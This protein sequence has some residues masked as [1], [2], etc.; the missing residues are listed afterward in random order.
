MTNPGPS[1]TSDFRAGAKVAALVLGVI[2]ALLALDRAVASILDAG[3]ARSGASPLAQVR[4]A[5]ADAV[6]VGTSTAKAA[7][8]PS[9]WPGKLVNLAQ[10]GQTVL[11][12]IAAARAML[13]APT[14][15]RIIIGIDPFDLASG[16]SNPAAQRIWRIA[17]LVA[18]LPE[19][20]PMLRQTRSV[21]EAPV[22]LESWRY[23]GE[24]GKIVNGLGKTD[25]PAYRPL[26]PGELREPQLNR[27]SPVRAHRMHASLEPYVT[28]LREMA[29]RPGR[30][31]VLVVTPAYR[32][33]RYDLPEQAQLLAELRQRLTG[34]PVCDLMSLDTPTLAQIRGQPANFFDNIH[35]SGQGA[36]AYTKELAA[37]VAAR[38]KS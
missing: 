37:L 23:R 22:A 36:A 24:V 14:V 27:S 25:P 35:L 4:H 6:V 2:A 17:P 9:I 8:V 38:C 30:Q 19:V 28:L 34:A 33:A 5:K 15:K 12:S 29:K 20:S 3:Y 16:L 11:F 32:N 18:T 1:S 26:P 7:F 21:T 31:L 13:D 10:D